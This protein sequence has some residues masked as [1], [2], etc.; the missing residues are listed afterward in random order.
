M[1]YAKTTIEIKTCKK[2]ETPKPLIEFESGRNT[3]RKCR[4]GRS[5]AERA[6]NAGI[7]HKRKEEKVTKRDYEPRE[8]S[9]IP[10]FKVYAE[11]ILS[12][13]KSNEWLTVAEIHRRIGEK[14]V[15]RQW[16]YDAITHNGIEKDETKMLDRFRVK[17]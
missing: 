1:N 10:E 11:L 15:I 17:G 8:L 16:T 9:Q 3:C 14:N 4:G 13:F 6:S 2:C 7:R 5:E 12:A